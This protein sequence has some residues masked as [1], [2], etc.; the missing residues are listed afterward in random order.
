V[1]FGSALFLYCLLCVRV[2]MGENPAAG[3]ATARCVGCV[4]ASAALR[5]SMGA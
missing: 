2:L 4:V 1:L 5:E 3:T